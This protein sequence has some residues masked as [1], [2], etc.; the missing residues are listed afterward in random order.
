[1]KLLY[2]TIQ[3]NMV[4]GLARI[5]IDKIN[6]L[7]DKGYDITLCNIEALDVKPAYP[8]DPRVKLIRGD[9]QTKPGGIMTRAKGVMG[10]VNRTKEVIRQEKPD[11]IINAHCPLVTWILP[12]VCRDIPKFVEIHQ[13][14][15]GLEVFNRQFMS[16]IARWGHRHAIKWIYS[17]Y[18][19][20]VVLTNGD[21][22]AWRCKN[23]IVIP[24]FV[25]LRYKT[26]GY[27]T[28][29]LRNGAGLLRN[30]ANG[31]YEDPNGNVLCKQSEQARANETLTLRNTALRNA[32]A[33]KTIGWNDNQNESQNENQDQNES[34]N[35]KVAK[36][37]VAK[38][39]VSVKKQILLLARLMPQKRIDLMIEVWAKL[40][41]EF[42]EWSVK[43]LGEGMLRPQ[44]EEK[45]RTLGLQESFLLPG[46]VK[47]V[48]DELQ[49]SD[50][51]CLTSEYEG[52][53][54]VLI[55]AM[56][57]GI[58]VIAFEYVGVHDIINNNVD[59]F[60]VPFGD[61]DAYAQKLKQLMTDKDLYERFVTEALTSVHKFDK[62]NIMRKWVE[63]FNGY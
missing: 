54:I 27:E 53:G 6:W 35:P 61:V 48:T 60:I 29:A 14:R 18:T 44:L 45:I 16:P 37:F 13:S 55:E 3:I 47:D 4:G 23:C 58:P 1:M 62:D 28:L 2:F 36:R 10:A 56:A 24:N 49:A 25:D 7:V 40:A 41:K 39:F 52:F 33:T 43:V 50:I 57:K 38:R 22:E 46:E 12:F 9:I 59:G 34:E 15:Q 11:I 5:V 30:V 31:Y 20:F 26:Q 51:L 17:R 8:I 63:V 19:R 32:D 21:K 42:P